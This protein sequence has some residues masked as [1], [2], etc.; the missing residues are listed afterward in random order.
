MIQAI[1][2]AVEAW[3]E[4][5]ELRDDLCMIVFQVV[6]DDL[7]GEPVRELV[8][9]NDPSRLNEMRAFV[10]EFLADVRAPV[11]PSSELLLAIG[12][13]T[14]NAARHGRID[15]RSEVR[16]RCSL[17]D[18]EVT[19]EVSDDGPGFEL[20]DELR[21]SPRDRFASGGRGIYLMGE[22]ADV[23]E[24][25]RTPEGTTVTLRKHVKRHRIHE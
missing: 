13:A 1:R 24:A 22:L 7:I 11:E 20:T 12:E 14:A 15:D 16:I 17:D 4:D 2:R 5:G 3:V 10:A 25:H 9:P 19:V 8:L 18:D 23:F 6:P 21:A